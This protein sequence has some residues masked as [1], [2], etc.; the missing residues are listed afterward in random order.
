MTH[1]E[2]TLRIL[3]LETS[4]KKA[5]FRIHL[6]E[7]GKDLKTESIKFKLQKKPVVVQMELFSEPEAVAMEA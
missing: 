2:L 1:E 6:L 5:N 4:L 3:C 7:K